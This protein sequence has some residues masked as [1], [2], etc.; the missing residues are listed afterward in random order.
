MFNSEKRRIFKNA[1]RK[2][3]EEYIRTVKREQAKK[4]FLESPDD[5]DFYLELLKGFEKNE[6]LRIKVKKNNGTEITISM[7]DIKNKITQDSNN[8]IDFDSLITSQNE[9][10]LGGR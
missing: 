2:A 1:K 5:Y 3:K 10:T 8:W 6:N 7:S 4:N 9:I